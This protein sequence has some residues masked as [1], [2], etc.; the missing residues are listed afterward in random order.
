[1]QCTFADESATP[2]KSVPWPQTYL[3]LPTTP[4]EEGLH[5]T[6]GQMRFGTTNDA[7][8]DSTND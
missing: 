2:Q 1:V 8:A 5:M 7:G 4:R 3:G 6:V